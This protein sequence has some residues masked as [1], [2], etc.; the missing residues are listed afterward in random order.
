MA[1]EFECS[2]G[3]THWQVQGEKRRPGLRLACHCADCQAF[4]HHL[5]HQDTLDDAGG[6]EVFQ[7][8]PADLEITIGEEN[9]RPL[10]L[11]PNGLIRW[12][13]TCCKSPIAFT[14]SNPRIAYLGLVTTP[15]QDKAPLGPLI[16]R[17]NTK[18]AT[19]PVASFGRA[20]AVIR[21]GARLAALRLG[22]GWK[23]SPLFDEDGQPIAAPYV[24]SREDRARAYENVGGTRAKA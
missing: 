9:V 19:K 12:Y 17:V 24:I 20:Q 23:R 3:K 15:V 1:I 11:S 21:I 10:R 5:G 8:R 7:I 2:C 14:P 18:T 4:A 13:A 22:G 16:A 6:T